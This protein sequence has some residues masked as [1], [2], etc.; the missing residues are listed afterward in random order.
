MTTRWAR[1]GGVAVVAAALGVFAGGMPASA[2]PIEHGRFHDQGSEL[3]VDFCGDLDVMNTWDINVSFLGRAKGP[4]GLIHFRDH[5]SGTNTFTNTET[6]RS[7]TGVFSINTQDA[8]V[9]DNGDGTLT[10]RV[11]GAGTERWYDGDGKLVLMNPGMVQFA[12][13]VD[14][15]GTPTDPSDDEFIE[16]LGIVRDSTGRNDTE[17]RDFCED[18]LLFTA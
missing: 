7:Y 18:L 10:I 17:G 5:A 1:A 8:R 15:N 11:K 16:D 14:H 3:L 12:F 2:A 13:L 6:G 4:D 9:T